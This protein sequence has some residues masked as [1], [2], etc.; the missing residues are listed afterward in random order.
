MAFINEISK[1][2]QAV[3]NIGLAFDDC[4]KAC[5]DDFEAA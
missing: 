1:D 2:K 4:S 5:M 3:T